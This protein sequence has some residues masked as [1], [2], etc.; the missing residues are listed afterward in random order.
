MYEELSGIPQ[1]AVQ[2]IKG[3]S[4]SSL[5]QVFLISYRASE[6]SHKED[7]HPRYVL[8]SIAT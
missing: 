6:A 5:R 4:D 3:E 2:P 8:L 7:R 1:S